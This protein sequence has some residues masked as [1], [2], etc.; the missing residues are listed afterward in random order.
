MQMKIP[1]IAVILIT[2]AVLGVV[3]GAVAVPL[4]ND[5]R[6]CASCH[7]IRPSYETWMTSTHKDVTC[8]ACHVRP[9]FE[10]FVQD[11]VVKG[12]HDVWVTLFGTP[13]KPEDLKATVHSEICLSCHQNMLRISELATR[14]LPGPLKKAGLI[15]EHRKHMEAFK[16]RQK[17]E[18]CTACHATVVHSTPYKGYPIVVPR[19][20]IKMDELPEAEARALEASMVKAHRGSDC[21]RCHDG[22]QEYEGKILSRKCETCHTEALSE[23]LF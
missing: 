17:G 2:L 14:D 12:T 20:H 6:F 9:T 4:T 13:K 5:P 16:K 21:F 15:M 8:V 7:T 19:G 11:K 1:K 3:A 22:K 23:T 10:G 18:G